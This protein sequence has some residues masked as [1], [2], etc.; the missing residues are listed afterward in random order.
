MTDRDQIENLMARYC[1]LYDD[2]DFESYAELFRHGDIGGPTGDFSTVEEIADYH[3]RNCLLYDG[4]PNTRHV[5]TN[6]EIHVD[7]EARTA[8]GGSYVT[9]YQATPDF[10]LQA[11]FVGSY[12]D[13]FH[14]VD[15]RWWFT[16]RRAVAH[17][18]GDLS[19]HAREYLP[20]TST[21]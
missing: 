2:G 7:D 8:T 21:G 14:E 11:I 3:R 6:I 19:R 16:E 4:V 12:L 1:R 10:P 9:I 17:L 13:R 18:V 5:V 20:P 15:G